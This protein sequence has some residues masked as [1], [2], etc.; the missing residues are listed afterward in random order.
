MGESLLLRFVLSEH[1]WL[2]VNQVRVNVRHKPCYVLQCRRKLKRIVV[3]FV[4]RFGITDDHPDRRPEHRSQS[5][6]TA[7]RVPRGWLGNAAI[8]ILLNH[9][10]SSIGQIPNSIGKISV[11]TRSQSVETKIPILAKNV[12]AR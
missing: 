10:Q 4:A 11:V 6:S 8:A 5:V 12:S 1:P 9:C 3:A 7:F 2:F